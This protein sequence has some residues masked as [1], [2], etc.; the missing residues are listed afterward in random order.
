[1]PT[2]THVTPGLRPGLSGWTRS[3]DAVGTALCG[4]FALAMAA[5]A[6]EATL[7]PDW[8]ARTWPVPWI[9]TAVLLLAWVPLRYL[10]KTIAAGSGA[11]GAGTG[12]QWPGVRLRT[13]RGAMGTAGVAEGGVPCR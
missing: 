3:A 12:Q 13:D 10:D 8:T 4:T 9:V 6:V 1:M 7:A 5:S 2:S 11:S